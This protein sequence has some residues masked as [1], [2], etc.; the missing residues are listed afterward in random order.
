MNSIVAMINK[1][2]L[3]IY[4]GKKLLILAILFL[5]IA[6]SSPVLAKLLPVILKSVP[7]TPGLT[8]NI[9]DPTWRDAIDQLVKNL[10]QIGMFV[11]IIIFAGSISEEK[12]KRTLEL[13][14]TKPVSRASFIVAKFLASILTVKLVFIIA[15]IVFYLYTIS[16][17]GSFSLVNFLWLSIFSLVFL[18]FVVALTLFFSTIAKSQIIAL[19]LVFFTEAVLAIL[20]ASIHRIDKYSPSYVFGKYKDLMANGQIQDF[21]PSV[22]VSI[23]AI[24]GFLLLSIYF[25][26]K[27]EIER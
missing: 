11:L 7:A 20:F 25:F 15:T 3:E 12:N 27:Q 16:I 14:L 9:P 18:A 5:F 10:S 21:L 26:R 2:L 23:I 17:L 1:E 6:I 22:T 8:I 24:V 13:V 19:A 4:R